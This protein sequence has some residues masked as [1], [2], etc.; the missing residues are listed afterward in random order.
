MC[1]SGAFVDEVEDGTRAD[2][3]AFSGDASRT[4]S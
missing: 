1:T 3:A 2:R 4:A